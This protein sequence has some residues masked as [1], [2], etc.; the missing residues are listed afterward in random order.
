MPAPAGLSHVAAVSFLAARVS[1][2]GS[3]WLSLTG[4]AATARESVLR[5]M[6]SGYASSAAAMLQTVAIVGPLRINAPLTQAVSAPLLGAMHARGRRPFTQFLA[7]L[8]IRLIHYTILTAFTVLILLGPKAYAGTYTTLF[9]WIPGLPKGLAGALILTA[10]GN[11]FFG[12]VFS[13]LQVAFY[14][15]ALNGWSARVP[16]ESAPREPLPPEPERPGGLDPRVALVVAT[17]V[18]IVLLVSHSWVVL[19]A[20]AAWLA[21]ASTMARYRDREVIRVGLLLALIVAVGTLAASL[22]GGLGL[23][24]AASRAVRGALL[25]MVPT[26]LRLAAGSAGLRE[27]FRRMLIRLHWIPGARE[28]GD[29]LG[30]LDSGALLEGSA[31][32]L[33]D[34]LRGITAEPMEI[35]N[36]VLMWAADEA[37][38]LPVHEPQAVSVLRLRP[39]D[40]TLVFSVLIPATALAAVL[41]PG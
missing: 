9:G 21:V 33:R 38:T 14:R 28:A 4:G 26:W 36:A 12:I 17:L 10:I 27:A 8:V 2:T 40:A 11:V 15:H 37:Q 29:I 7:A 6:R 1:P 13:A 39:R 34:R 3:F 32:A 19:G 18:T 30:E 25:V 35:V 23:D 31:K 20:V 41:V 24:E 5:G 22:I 16:A